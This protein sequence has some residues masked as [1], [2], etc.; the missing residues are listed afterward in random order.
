MSHSNFFS[1]LVMNQFLATHR[2][3]MLC[4]LLILPRD[5]EAC[6]QVYTGTV[7]LPYMPEKTHT[8]LQKKHS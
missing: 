8:H 7:I 3:Q 2:G 5:I 6:P 1:L 4:V